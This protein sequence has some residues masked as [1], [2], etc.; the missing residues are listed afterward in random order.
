[1][2]DVS[3]TTTLDQYG[4]LM[5]EVHQEAAKRLDVQLFGGF[6]RFTVEKAKGLTTGHVVSP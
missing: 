6:E 2:A 3:I 5:P 1:M 4:H